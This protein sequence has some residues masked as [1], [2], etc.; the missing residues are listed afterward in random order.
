MTQI[1]NWLGLSDPGSGFTWKFS[2]KL[3]GFDQA[4]AQVQPGNLAPIFRTDWHASRDMVVPG[5]DS[6]TRRGGSH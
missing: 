2:M 1:F 4:W 6:H 3:G 5:R